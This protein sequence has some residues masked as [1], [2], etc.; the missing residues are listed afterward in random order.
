MANI[1]KNI[2]S[3]FCPHLGTAVVIG[4]L[5]SS[6]AVASHLVPVAVALLGSAGTASLT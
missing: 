3:T 2:E 4:Q 5:S 6:N 1:G